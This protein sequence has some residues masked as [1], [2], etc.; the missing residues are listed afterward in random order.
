VVIFAL[1]AVDHRDRRTT[2]RVTSSLSAAAQEVAHAG[3]AVIIERTI[4]MFPPFVA[5][6][7]DQITAIFINLVGTAMGSLFTSLFSSI[8][9]NFVTPIFKSLA[10]GLGLPA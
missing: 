5:S 4:P 6:F 7:G 2:S 3:V 9:T 10:A 1:G 8:V